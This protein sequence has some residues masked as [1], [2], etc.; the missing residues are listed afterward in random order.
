MPNSPEPAKGAKR[1]AQNHQNAD[2]IQRSK[3]STRP[4]ERVRRLRISF[5][6]EESTQTLTKDYITSLLLLTVLYLT[7]SENKNILPSRRNGI[8]ILKIDPQL[9][10]H[11]NDIIN[12]RLSKN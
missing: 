9:L 3:S 2:N 10:F 11:K 4:V 5:L 12:A 8:H 7:A 6:K 1:R